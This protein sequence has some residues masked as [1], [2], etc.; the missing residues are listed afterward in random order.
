MTEPP[1]GL[2]VAM[3]RFWA[4]ASSLLR[5]PAAGV[6]VALVGAFLLA[7]SSVLA[8]GSGGASRGLVLAGSARWIA[9]GVRLTGEWENNVV[10]AAWAPMKVRVTDGFEVA[11][12]LRLTPAHPIQT[13]DDWAY[14]DGAALVLQND[15]RGLAARG[16]DG[17]SLGYGDS[18]TGAGIATSVAVEFDTLLSGEP[19]E[20]PSWNHVG[21]Q[22][23]GDE[24]N[25]HDHRHSLGA[26]SSI[27]NLG[28][29]AVHKIRIRYVPG[30]LT[31]FVD[32]ARRLKVPLR[33]DE[34]LTL[35]GGTAWIGMSAATG[36]A[37]A[38]HD[39]VAFSY[40]L[41]D[42]T[43]SGEL[44]GH[45][46]ATDTS[47]STGPSGLPWLAFLSASVMGLLGSLAYLRRASR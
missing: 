10:G 4:A 37:T 12:A 7:S 21:V 31:V 39:V 24:P 45:A 35:P 5:L 8:A 33:L 27:P 23:R 16:G 13:L 34:L 3:S 26:T 11:L 38:N 47:P 44:V 9:T 36:D 20:D 28:D 30:E 19:P 1:S 22:S 43:A 25:D 41:A 17:S 46:P 14:G 6:A 15:P 18:E 42:G 2:E 32:G 29:G 40:T